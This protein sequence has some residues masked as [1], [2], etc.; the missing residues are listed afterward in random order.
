MPKSQYNK[1]K[2]SGSSKTMPKRKSGYK[3]KK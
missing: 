1:K 3:R 2:G